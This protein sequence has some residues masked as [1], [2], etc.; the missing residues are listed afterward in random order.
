MAK[1]IN[2]SILKQ[3]TIDSAWIP[4]AP[5]P[6]FFVSILDQVGT[7]SYLVTDGTYTGIVT[8]SNPSTPLRAITATYAGPTGYGVGQTLTVQG[9]I[10]YSLP[11]GS[12][13][14]TS[15]TVSNM[16]LHSLAINA[17]GSGYAVGDRVTLAGG[18][19]TTAAVIRVLTLSTTA[20]ATFSIV[21]AG[22]YTTTSTSFTQG[23]TSGVGT[24]ATF[25]T[26]TFSIN[27]TTI[28]NTGSFVNSGTYSQLPVN[29]AL[30]YGGVGSGAAFN[31]TWAAPV[32]VIGHAHKRVA[33]NHVGPFEY[34][35]VIQQNQ[36]K[37]FQSHTYDWIISGTPTGNQ[38]YLNP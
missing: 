8:L 36:L 34:V 5:G 23:S 2:S 3:F 37:T 33:K 18:T 35:S 10:A 24:G 22:V 4:G 15:L 14:E 19:H 32:T 7:S 28:G 29:P 31:L 21:N 38:V 12:G 11:S 25:Q 17:G 20:I 16:K 9:G 1:P 27:A 13:A 26:G 30:A 6:S